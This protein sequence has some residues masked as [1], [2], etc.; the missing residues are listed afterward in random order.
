MEE[1][2]R[3]LQI[4]DPNAARAAG[5]EI[6]QN[7]KERISNESQLTYSHVV[8]VKICC[9][10]EEYAL[11]AEVVAHDWLV[12]DKQRLLEDPS[13][14]ADSILKNFVQYYY[15]SALVALGVADYLRALTLL[16]VTVKAH[17]GMP[18]PLQESA[19]KKLLL[20]K[21]LTGCKNLN[22]LDERLEVG[23][24]D[25]VFPV[26]DHY[27]EALKAGTETCPDPENQSLWDA[28]RHKLRVLQVQE[29]LNMFSVANLD[30]LG[31]ADEIRAMADNGELQV[32]IENG[33]VINNS[34]TDFRKV[35][36]KISEATKKNND[37]K[38][39]IDYLHSEMLHHKNQQTETQV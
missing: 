36:D 10:L 15:Y 37:L 29:K 20:V 27:V 18:L 30:L 22:E 25:Y 26:H 4:N 17:S 5:L 14:S 8:F 24:L 21:I 16:H 2:K 19:A 7:L 39:Q 13:D 34:P 9:F 23:Y 31:P 33:T 35:M 38:T 1:L 32:T 3:F 6:A 11:A 28:V 12:K